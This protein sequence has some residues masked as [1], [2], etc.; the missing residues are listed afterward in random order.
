[1]NNNQSLKEN[2]YK[3][4]ITTLIITL[5]LTCILIYNLYQNY[6]KANDNKYITNNQTKTI[7]KK[8]T[9]LF[10]KYDTIIKSI[11]YKNKKY[12][13]TP[14]K[15][16][17]NNK[18]NLK[19]D[20][21]INNDTISIEY[22]EIDNLLKLDINYYQDT[23]RVINKETMEIREIEVKTTEQKI[24]N[25]DNNNKNDNQNNN[26]IDNIETIFISLGLGFI[27]GIIFN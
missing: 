20:S 23:F 22:K 27:V 16:K 3:Y 4:Y 19:M 13:I 1:M 8:D 7:I 2:N 21:I 24:M 9:I 5:I 10:V 11:P 26:L 15:T 17:E 25:F 12:F 18:I 6:Q 14:T